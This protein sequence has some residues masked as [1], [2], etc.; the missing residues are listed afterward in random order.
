MLKESFEC[1]DE[2]R[3]QKYLKKLGLER[4]AVCDREFLDLLITTHQ[5]RIPFE[6]LEIIWKQQEICTDLDSVYEKMVEHE[7]GGYCF[8]LNALFLGLLRGLGYEAYPVACRV[9][10][11]D[12]IGIPT[13][14]ASVVMLDGKKYFCDVGFGGISCSCAALMETGAKTETPIGTFFFEQEYEGWVNLCFL[15]KGDISSVN[16]IM[17]AAQYPSAPIDFTAANAAMQAPES[18]FVKFMVLQKK[19]PEGSVAIDGDQFITRTGKE[20]QIVQLSSR[21]ETERIVKEVFG[22]EI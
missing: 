5:E 14:R 12:R 20:K 19:T 2:K 8:E 3:C 9:L 1:L 13:H 21:E 17:M 18:R 22:I 11:F 16:R 10:V 7:R 4:P 6:N 15:A